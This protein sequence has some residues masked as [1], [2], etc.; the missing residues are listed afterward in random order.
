[1]Y[2]YSDG[3]DETRSRQEDLDLRVSEAVDE[4]EEGIVAKI[5]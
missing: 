1:M 5:M 3:S 4:Q 2:S